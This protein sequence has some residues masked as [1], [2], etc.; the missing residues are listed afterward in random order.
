MLLS[1]CMHVNLQDAVRA[2]W[3]GSRG[4]RRHMVWI[5]RGERYLLDAQGDVS[6]DVFG[7][8]RI[9]KGHSLHLNERATGAE[10][11]WF[12]QLPGTHVIRSV[13]LYVLPGLVRIR[14]HVSAHAPAPQQEQ[15]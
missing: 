13:D 5:V 9:R 7:S 6:K 10:R 2:G 11:C 14:W 4:M 8:P 15:Q 1:D 12:W 3:E